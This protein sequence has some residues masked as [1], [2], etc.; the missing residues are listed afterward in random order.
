MVSPHL[1]H[2]GHWKMK[3][4]VVP[5]VVT[6]VRYKHCLNVQPWVFFLDHCT[7]GGCKFLIC[8]LNFIEIKLAVSEILRVV[9]EDRSLPV[10]SFLQLPQDAY[11]IF[12]QV[13]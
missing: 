2:M 3:W 13:I 10:F 6:L 8:H 5:N 7:K 11:F 12:I 4:W 1:S 9:E